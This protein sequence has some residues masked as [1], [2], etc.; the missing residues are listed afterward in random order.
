MPGLIIA[1]VL[2]LALSFAC[3]LLEAIVLSVTVAEI[4][5]LKKA[6]GRRGQRFETM[7]VEIDQ[8]ISAILTLNTIAGGIGSVIVGALSSELFGRHAMLYVTPAFAAVLLLGSEVLPKNIG[9]VHRRRLLPLVASPLWWLRRILR[10][11]TWVCNHIVRV[12]VRA[13]AHLHGSD[14]EIILLAERG[15]KQ[16]TLTASESSIIANALS[17]E[18]V[19]VNAIMTPRTVVSALRRDATVGDVFREH[20][21]LR[22]GRL[23][24]YGRN[25]DDVV[26]LVRRRDLLNAKAR[27]QDAVTV[28]QV[29]KP[30]FF[31]PETITVAAALQVFIRNHQKLLV[32]VDEFGAT[33]GV[34]TME[35]VIEHLLGLEFFETD[36]YAVDMREL[37]RGRLT[38]QSARGARK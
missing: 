36:D 27:D 21:E 1:T 37:A 15:A 24:V 31:I 33:A 11:V 32:V 12:F 14:E 5:S 23:P 20:P 13:P 25:L 4:E 10:P 34:V 18:D 8:T 26:G 3:S 16:G 28:E 30:A 7:R 35:D 2:T 19:R 29:M 38:K 6:G 17:L 22:F 9:V